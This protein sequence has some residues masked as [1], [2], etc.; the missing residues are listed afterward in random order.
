MKASQDGQRVHCTSWV[1]AFGWVAVS[2][3]KGGVELSVLVAGGGEG[4]VDVAARWCRTI[5]GAEDLRDHVGEDVRRASEAV[6]A[7]RVDREVEGRT[8][9]LTSHLCLDHPMDGVDLVIGSSS[10]S[11]NQRNASTA[12]SRR[13]SSSV[14]SATSMAVSMSPGR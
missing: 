2:D 8:P 9:A 7:R 3:A 1:A 12:S 4:V 14:S 10:T 11:R 6:D 5:G 13:L